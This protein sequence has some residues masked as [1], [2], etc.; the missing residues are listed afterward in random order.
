[1][2]LSVGV[3][4]AESEVRERN[5]K[6]VCCNLKRKRADCTVRVCLAEAAALGVADRS[7]AHR[8]RT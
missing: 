7:I 1:M 3:V 2:K 6:A 8:G 5:G 4:C